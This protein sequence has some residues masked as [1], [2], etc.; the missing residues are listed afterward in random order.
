MILCRNMRFKGIENTAEVIEYI[1]NG[2][3]IWDIY[4]LCKTDNKNIMEIMELSQFNIRHYRKKKIRVFGIAYKKENAIL[5]AK[6]II[7]EYY[8][9]SGS[10]LGL[11]E[12]LG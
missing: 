3:S 1:K 11:K 5:L 12:S 10:L 4:L 9:E 8:N 7:E 6:E 2:V